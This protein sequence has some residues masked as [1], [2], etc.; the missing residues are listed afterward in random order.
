V[1]SDERNDSTLPRTL[2]VVDAVIE[3]SVEAE[4]NE[5][6]D[7][8]H[9]PEILACPHFQ[10]GARYVSETEGGRKYL[11]VYA[12]SSEEAVRTPEFTKARG[13]GRFKERVRFSTRLYTRLE[14]ASHGR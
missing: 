7:S 9:L 11:T 4:W 1:T 14:G 12:L 6:Y 13:W 3:P 10:S 2:L 5:W 8:E